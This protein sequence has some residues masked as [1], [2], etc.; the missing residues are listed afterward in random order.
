MKKLTNLLIILFFQLSAAAQQHPSLFVPASNPCINYVGRFDISD[1]SKPVFMYSG[2]AIMAS[3]TGTALSIKLVDDSLRNWFTVIIDDSVF[4]FEANR[5]DGIYQLANNLSNKKH[6][7]EVNRRT[8]WHG[9]NT[10]FE[11]FY[12]AAGEKIQPTQKTKRAIEFIGDSFTCGYGNEGKSREEHFLYA[13]ENNYLTY[14]AIAARALEADYIGICRS[15]IGLYQGYGGDTTFAMPDFYDDVI[16]NSKVKWNYAAL[17]P[18]MVVIDL[19]GNDFSAAVDSVKFA[20]AYLKFLRTIRRNY[21]AA[22]IVCAAG[23][24]SPGEKFDLQKSYVNAVVKAFQKTDKDVHYFAFQA[25]GMNGSDW[26]P[27]VAEHK[28]MANELIPFL[29]ALLKS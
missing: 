28:V 9:G 27:N 29:K 6:R 20:N 18:K 3:F 22:L 17:Q 4:S 2:S 26:H 8:E 12:I 1:K 19:S 14:G 11:G 13:T 7:V 5:K 21:P 10:T 16:N 23:P 24:S 25:F 15:G